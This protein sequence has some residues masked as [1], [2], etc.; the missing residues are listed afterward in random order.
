MNKVKIY[1]T[2]YLKPLFCVFIS[3][4][5]FHNKSFSQV[6]PDWKYKKELFHYLNTLSDSVYITD[7]IELELLPSASCTDTEVRYYTVTKSGEHI[8][9]A[10]KSK[11]F[12]A[13]QHEL[14]LVDTFFSILNNKK[15]VDSITVGNKIDNKFAYGIR[16]NIPANE[17]S[18]F[19]VFRNNVKL[20]IPKQAYSDLYNIHF[21]IYHKAPEVYVT[22]NNKY[23]YIYLHGSD[24]PNQY[25]VKIIF[26][27][28]GYV[29][30]IVNKHP[31]L[32]D[33]DFIDGFGDCQ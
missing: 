12:L 7:R 29:T 24:G 22:K 25:S 27:K 14:Q 19:I 9:L 26:N 15:V 21:C 5:C 3:L 1:R 4:F 8:Q 11:V 20:Q 31:C 13:S 33:F 16:G 2:Y 6:S 28:T 30:R 18:S 17:V 10:I 32:T 23:V